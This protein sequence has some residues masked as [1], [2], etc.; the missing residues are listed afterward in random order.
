MAHHA[1]ATAPQVEGRQAG[2]EARAL[3]FPKLGPVPSVSQAQQPEAQVAKRP[4]VPVRASALTE[5][6]ERLQA[7][8]LKRQ[9]QLGLASASPQE[10]EPQPAPLEQPAWVRWPQEA[11]SPALQALQQARLAQV[12]LE[13]PGACA[14]LWLRPPSHLCPPWPSLRRPLLHPQR[15]EGACGPSR[16]HRPESSSSA[17]SFLV[18][19]TRAAGR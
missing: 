16:Q 14:P 1:G 8:P 15:R 13:P 10:A 9:A 12:L 2:A 18:R 4:A 6:A 7:S 19:R 17:F 11:E 3:S 5:K